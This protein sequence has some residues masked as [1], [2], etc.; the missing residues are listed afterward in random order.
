M[1]SPGGVQ[2][3]RET[4]AWVIK[5]KIENAPRAPP[6]GVASFHNLELTQSKVIFLRRAL[7]ACAA[8]TTMLAAHRAL[9]SKNSH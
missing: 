1:I 8:M 3:K 4:V 7:G 5:N 9:E 2:I 6:R